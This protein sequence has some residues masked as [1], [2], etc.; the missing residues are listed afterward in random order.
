MSKLSWKIPRINSRWNV[1]DTSNTRICATSTRSPVTLI[2]ITRL[3]SRYRE[4]CAI[5]D[6]AY[7]FPARNTTELVFFRSRRKS[8]TDPPFAGESIFSFLFHTAIIR[9]SGLHTTR[10]LRTT[11]PRASPRPL[12]SAITSPP[13]AFPPFHCVG[14]IRRAGHVHEHGLNNW[15]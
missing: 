3:L 14:K 12:P 2:Q 4:A 11:D 13:R 9:S 8:A 7:I 5:V 1:Y 6:G 15:A 10:Y